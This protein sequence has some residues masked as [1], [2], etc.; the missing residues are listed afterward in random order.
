MVEKLKVLFFGLG[1]IGTKHLSILQRDYDFDLY[2]Y[3]SRENPPVPDIKN[4][5]ALEKALEINPDIVFITNPIEVD[6]E[7]P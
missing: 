5:Y 2:A 6:N 7:L 3:R 4:I 1:S